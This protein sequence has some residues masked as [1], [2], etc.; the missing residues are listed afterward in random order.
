MTHTSAVANLTRNGQWTSLTMLALGMFVVG[1]GEF[2]VVGLAEPISSSLGVG[3]VDVGYLNS[4]FAAGM[5][6]GAPLSALV[7]LRI[8]RLTCIIAS[9]AFYAVFNLL[10]ALTHSFGALMACRL[11]AAFATSLYCVTAL[12]YAVQ[13]VDPRIRGRSISLLLTGFTISNVLGV[14]LASLLG[15]VLGWQIVFVGLAGLSLIVVVLVHFFVD[16]P[17]TARDPAATRPQLFRMEARALANRRVVLSLMVSCLFQASVFGVFSYIT[18]LL[19]RVSGLSGDAVA[20]VLLAYGVGTAIGLLFGGWLTDRAPWATLILGIA[21]AC[22]CMLLLSV[23]LTRAG[24]SCGVLVVQ[25]VVVF[26]TAAPINER[27]LSMADGAPTFATAINTSALNLGNMIG[28]VVV[29]YALTAGLGLRW[30]PMMGAAGL[31][32]AGTLAIAAYMSVRSATGSSPAPARYRCR[33][34][35]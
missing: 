9:G 24:L 16:A 14:P 32:L 10:A 2:V 26:I 25:G 20:G 23:S 30:L 12:L 3:V 5:V 19:T 18:I 13:T 31:A 15:V 34:S 11:L 7:A 27:V 22:V 1:T 29:G 6:V 4:A 35:S 21:V 33:P 28:P 8:D 17:R